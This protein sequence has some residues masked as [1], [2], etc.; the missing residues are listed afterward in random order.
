[1]A[2]VEPD[3]KPKPKRGLR[4]RLVRVLVR[5]VGLVVVLGVLGGAFLHTRWG[6]EL[7]RARVEAAL[8]DK[9][10]GTV[11]LATLDYGFLFDGIDLGG[12]A[13]RDRAG[14]DAV[15][16]G[17][18][19]LDLDRGSLLGGAPVINT[20]DI[21]GLVVTVVQTPDGRTNLASL[22]KPS[23]SVPPASIRVAALAVHGEGSLTQLDGTVLGLH[24]VV[25]T[26]SLTARP[27]AQELDALL[28]GL[29]AEVSIVRP[30]AAT[31]TGQLAI[32]FARLGRH[33][34]GLELDVEKLV[35]GALSMEAVRGRIAIVDGRFA[36]AQALTLV[37]GHVDHTKLATELGRELLADDADLDATLAGP[38]KLL[39]VHGAVS[40]RHTRLT[41]DGTGDLSAPARPRYQ[42]A[43]VGAGTSADVISPGAAL[44]VPPIETSVRLSIV[45]AGVTRADLEAA[46]G[47]EIG[48]TRVGAVALDGLTA[49]LRATRG[50]LAI[51]ELAA[52]GRGFDL[53]AT[54]EVAADTEL[55]ARVTIAIRPAEALPMLTAAGIVLPR[56]LPPLAPFTLAVRA[57]GRIDGTVD[58]QLEP[59]RLAVAGGGVTIAGTARVTQKIVGDVAATIALHD[60][61]LR[62]LAG[63]AGKPPP[64]V[65]GTLSGH[66]AVARIGGARRATYDL[67]IALRE[68]ALAIAATG[69]SDGSTA[70]TRATVTRSADHV[71]LATLTAVLPIDQ[72][73]LVPTRGWHV[74]VAVAR[75]S[76][77]ELLALVPPAIR[78]T[79]PPL[80]LPAGDL[81]LGA[82]LAGTPARPRGTIDASLTATAPE[83]GPELGPAH[84]ELH[85]AVTP[86]RGGG[87]TVATT[88]TIAADPIPEPL[89][90]IHGELALPALFTG[91]VLDPARVRAGLVID[92]HLEVPE[93]TLA[94]LPRVPAAVV[95]L[96]GVIGG[97]VAVRGPPSALALD[98][99]I[100]WRGYQTAGGGEGV[101]TLALTGTPARLALTVVHAG[102]LTLT[103]DLG[104][105][106]DRFT[107]TARTAATDAPL[108]SLLPALP[109]F[110]GEMLRGAELGRLRTDLGGTFT[111]VRGPAGV[112]VVE[113]AN[114][115]GALAVSGGAFALP[116]ASRR[117][118]DI[119]LELVGDPRGLRLGRLDVHE[120]DA[121]VPDRT[122]HAS[123]LLVLA[124]GKPQTASVV[125]TTRD[126]LALGSRSPLFSDAPT[127]AVDLDAHVTADLTA[128][129]IAADV[130]VDHL[131]LRN[132]D[133]RDRAHLPET[134]SIA[135][136]VIFVD[137]PTAI[138]KLPGAPVAA[139]VGSPGEGGRAIDVHIH[140]PTPIHAIRAPLDI[141]ATGELSVTV[142]GG[143]V[144]TRGDVKLLSGT[145][146]TFGQ[147]HALLDGHVRFTAAHPHGELELTFA[148]PLP[149]W[150]T[151]D[152]ARADRGQRIHLTGEPAKPIVALSGVAN[153][154][155]PE[156]FSTYFAGH[157]QFL[158]PP[159]LPASA[160]VEVPRGDQENVLAYLSL[161]L[162]QLLFL[163]RVSAWADA[164]ESRGAYGRI[165]NAVA[166]RYMASEHARVRGVARPTT[167]GRS[168]AEMQW[169]R[170]LVHDAQTL[171]GAGVR[172][173]DRLG[174]GVGLFFEWASAE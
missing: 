47:V 156:V 92:E 44:A 83:L 135:G 154:T 74:T 98:A 29:T 122:L 147:P 170:L 91:R 134:S 152:V 46:I 121:Q 157:P 50:A 43:L 32:G 86:A 69:R 158:A 141:T 42:L 34:D 124:K 67:A 149:D 25:V 57:A 146:T 129:V 63:L 139:E 20:L 41:L 112:V 90:T 140:I 28:T 16:V 102:A 45:G 95:A 58:I 150:S 22:A 160:T 136:D 106:G 56:R 3:Q 64:P 148:R 116:H 79:L 143:A 173:G 35:L 62:A 133:R 87:V 166:E 94:G 33:A 127:A 5:L 15:S 161:V 14:R 81:A 61:G 39:A 105:V 2:D 119:A 17:A 107:I 54:A 68:P 10:D 53:G 13:I 113:E 21:S 169:D 52:H 162:P 93:R 171:V 4:R 38:A 165:R 153:D 49:K 26:G 85:A 117:W 164:H 11:T 101:T 80:A 31:T 144:A 111:I 142:R 151:R 70:T 73:G 159:G 23:G 19:H 84:V 96:G 12:I 88:G 18:V 126:W 130:T 36:G 66:L 65:D 27:A 30:G 137:D 163:D 115:T 59:T 1:M 55:H 8:G 109:M 76:L 125:L 110:A 24:D 51:D 103:A 75:R 114:L 9:V 123:G 168:T 48:P 99:Q 89:A 7:V 131:E 174:G 77:T 97:H 100:G 40:T 6:K 72:R 128:P 108:L 60:L 118:H 78:A 82:D 172:V 71:L 155:L 167:P 138:G 120:T 145:L 104:H 132:P 37:G